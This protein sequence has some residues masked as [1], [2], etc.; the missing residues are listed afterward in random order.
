MTNALYRNDRP[1]QFPKSYYVTTV[2]LPPERPALHGEERAD[3]CIVGAGYTGLVA[4][5]T[6]AERGLSVVVLDAQ[7]AGWGASGRNG[8]QVG[9]G[10]HKP[11]SWLEARVGRPL[12][13]QMWQITEDA[14]ALVRDLSTRH[15][16]EA[17]YRPG[18]AYGAYSTN[19][20]REIEAEVEL[21]HQHYG[22][23]QITPLAGDDFR[24]VVKSPLYACGHL[25]R[26][27]GHLNPLRFVLGLARAAEAAGVRIFERS[28]VHRITHGD[29]A[30]VQTSRGRVRAGHVLLA[31]NGYLPRIEPRVSARV[32]P[33]NSFIGA[34]EPLT[35][36]QREVLAEDICAHDSSNVVNYFRFEDGRFLFGGRAN[37]SLTFPKDMGGTLHKRMIQMFPQLAGVRFDYT[38]GGS[39]GVTMTR[40]PAAIRVAPNVLSISGYSGHGLALSCMSGRIMAETVAGQAGQFDVLAQLPGRPFPLGT[41]L[42]EQTMGLAMMW[43]RM[44]DK[45]GI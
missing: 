17:N 30:L 41:V 18:N 8:G 36:R 5:L 23:D 26:G 31:G 34:T 6:L 9:S 2:D 45:L 42:Q 11:Q 1:G 24:E 10:H 14:K 44:R 12:A 22:Y 35:D 19:D 25:D 28:E 37:Y 43:F 27:A 21:L 40:L 4:A 7:R 15:A 16:P 38:W 13:R 39:L 3:V 20:F 32:M 29:P 33:I